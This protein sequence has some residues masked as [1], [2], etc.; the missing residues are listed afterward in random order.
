ML[1]AGA[2]LA[3]SKMVKRVGEVDEFEFKAIG[4]NHN[5]GVRGLVSYRSK[6]SLL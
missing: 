1:V 6:V 3:G 4:P 5:Q 2:G